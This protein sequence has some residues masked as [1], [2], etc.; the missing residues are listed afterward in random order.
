MSF[1]DVLQECRQS[2]IRLAARQ[3]RLLV[4]GA[5]GNLTAALRE[6]L[7]AH[8]AEILAFLGGETANAA[9]RLQP[10]AGA[11]DYPLSFSQQRLWFIDQLEHGSVEYNIPTAFR[12]RGAL[13]REALVAA[14]NAIVARHAVLRTRFAL[15]DGAPVQIVRDVAAFVPYETD[16]SALQPAVRDAE[17]LRLAD[18]EAQRPFDLANDALLRCT[19]IRLGDDEHAVLFTVHH[20]AADGWSMG[21]LVKEFVALYGAFAQGGAD[22]LPPLPIQYGDYAHWQRTAH[23]GG[24]LDEA[25]NYWQQRLAGLPALHDLP[26]DRP[27][28]ARQNF[29]AQRHARWLDRATLDGLRTFAKAGGAT[30]FMALQ[31][32]FAALL[33][34]WSGQRDIVIGTPTAGRDQPET[35]GLIGF[36][37]NTLVCRYVVDSGDSAQALLAQGRCVA[38]DAFTHQHAPFDLLVETLRPE[39]SLAYNPL[40]QIKFVLQNHDGGALELPGLVLEP[41][42][43]GGERVHFDLDLTASEGEN[44]LQ[45]S[46]T[47]KEE[48][49][50]AASIERLAQAYELLLRQWL[51]R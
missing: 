43:K 1:L 6:R 45:L 49:F 21:L 47:Y 30:L 29:S 51:A 15:K 31:S 27:R 3:G 7:S 11:D 41:V 19:L 13:D 4:D 32:A 2:G 17:L 33:S 25:L 39:R 50:D 35:A 22:P 24:L 26:L 20:I 48:L 9:P 42:G 18:A 14:L 8:K 23:G 36:F 12:L 16:L 34:R 37:N 44:G 5:G 38:L 46:W 10:V 28:P 40:C